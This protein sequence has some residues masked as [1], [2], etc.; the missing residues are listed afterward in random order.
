MN[1]NKS[2][3]QKD[4][5][6]VLVP[7]KEYVDEPWQ[8]DA[9]VKDLKECPFVAVY[10]TLRT[11]MHNQAFRRGCPTVEE[12]TRKGTISLVKYGGY[13]AYSP[14]GDMDVEFEIIQVPTTRH[15]ELLDTL[16]GYP[17]LYTRTIREFNCTSDPSKK[18][19]AWVYELSPSSIRSITLS[20]MNTGSFPK[21]MEEMY[22]FPKKRTF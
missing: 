19:N 14:V 12:A 7:N 4:L 5:S 11:G 20:P 15:F 10:G 9:L 8:G 21:F 13:P 18:M 22:R 6:Y 16:E 1:K 3:K 2:N 17:S